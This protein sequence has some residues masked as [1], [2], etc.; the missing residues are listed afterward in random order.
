MFFPAV[1]LLLSFCMSKQQ[2]ETLVHFYPCWAKKKLPKCATQ[3][4][5]NACTKS[6]AH[7]NSSTLPI[8]QTVICTQYE[9]ITFTFVCHNICKPC[10]LPNHRNYCY[11]N[12]QFN[13]FTKHRRR[14]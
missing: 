12:N 3:R 7:K 6:L 4:K 5:L 9:K 10:H 2:A 1:E 8:F 11:K 14:K 13:V